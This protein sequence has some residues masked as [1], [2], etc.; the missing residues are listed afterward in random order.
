M[1]RVKTI[2]VNTS[3][4]KRDV[5]LYESI[6][7]RDGDRAVDSAEFRFPVNAIVDISDTIYYIQDVT[8]LD[9]LTAIWNFQYSARD[10]SGNFLDGNDGTGGYTADFIN[11]K[12][13]PNNSG[14]FED[15]YSIRFN[16]INEEVTVPHNTKFDFSGQFDIFIWYIADAVHFGGNSNGKKQI[17]FSKFD[18]DAGGNGIEIGGYYYATGTFGPAWH[19]YARIRQN[20]TTTE[21]Q[22]TSNTYYFATG[23]KSVMIRLSRDS[24]NDVKLFIEKIQD[25]GTQNI[26]GSLSNTK[27]IKIG[28]NSDGTEDYSGIIHQIRVYCG[29]TLSS[30]ESDAVYNAIPQPLT[31]KFAGAVWKKEDGTDDKK[32]FCTGLGSFIMRTNVT[33]ALLDNLAGDNIFSNMKPGEI[34][35]SIVG[36]IDSNWIVADTAPGTANITKFVAEGNLQTLIEFLVLFDQDVFWTSPRKVLIKEPNRK[37]RYAFTEHSYDIT[38]TGDDDSMTVND[39]EIM[40][41]NFLYSQEESITATSSQTVFTLSDNP[42]N[43]RVYD[44][45]VFQDPQGASGYTVDFENKQVTFS[46]GRTAGNTIRFEYDYEDMRTTG[47]NLDNTAYVVKTD[48][49]SINKIGR[50]SRR[51]YAPYYR[52]RANLNTIATNYVTGDAGHKDIDKRVKLVIPGLANYLREHWKISVSNSLTGISF[53][54]GTA[55]NNGIKIKSIEWRFPEGTTTV[56]CGQHKFNDFEIE[57][58]KVDS[59]EGLSSSL[60]KT[61]V[62]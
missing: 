25:G 54:I 9:S 18:S 60:V 42:I 19:I 34:I 46:T 27:D 47:S 45:G 43:L 52:T 39:L 59:M 28:T 32:V 50:Y 4:E 41:Q 62:T 7:T 10:E 22:G 16:N 48:T 49:T 53:P 35:K 38:N 56:Q 13:A 21:I 33:K 11:P 24:N 2:A 26:S 5:E 20:G 36:Q 12:T 51:L 14:K 23:S 61:K 29:R 6:V 55:P 40:G 30:D 31:M 44:N 15:L 1:P 3:G 58:R 37:S 8:N 57:K 17:I